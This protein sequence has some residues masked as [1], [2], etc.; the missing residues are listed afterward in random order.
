MHIFIT[1]G[2]RG[3]GNGL[4]KQ[5]LKMNHKVTFTGTSQKSITQAQ[6]SLHGDYLACICD[7][8]YKS[9]IEIARDLAINK[10]GKIDIWINNAGVDQ[11]RL[12]VAK[13]SEDEIKRVIDI[14]VTGMM[15]GTSVAL[16]MMIQNKTGCIYNMEGLGSNG[17]MIPKTLIYGS[18]KRL[19]TYFS[20]GCNKE[21]KDYEN[22]F[23][24]TLQ[25][26]MVF[27]E[28]LMSNMD[29]EGM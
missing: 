22:I 18:S 1:G 8:R 5:F 25:P 2:T 26:G 28:L 20:K 14:N 4:V 13:L 24:G 27:T 29:E 15:V 19:L 7:V 23:V 3:I 17:M 21:L 10:F 12:E 6:E 16:D 11:Q 9:Q